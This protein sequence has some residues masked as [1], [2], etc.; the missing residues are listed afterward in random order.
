MPIVPKLRNP[1]LRGSPE[2]VTSMHLVIM[3]MWD[4]NLLSGYWPRLFL[5]QVLCGM[6]KADYIVQ[7]GLCI[8]SSKWVAWD[9]VLSLENG[10]SKWKVGKLTMAE[11]SAW[12]HHGMNHT[13]DHCENPTFYVMWKWQRMAMPWHRGGQI[14]FYYCC[15]IFEVPDDYFM[16]QL[17]DL[18]GNNIHL[19][20]INHEGP[21]RI[22]WPCHF[23]TVR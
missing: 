5:E 9:L 4:L 3:I 14:A 7:D 1:G 16:C 15:V 2:F 12:S 8:R 18:L 13:S 6:T 22:S 21:R 17:F 10:E 19:N 23:S 11:V 20:I